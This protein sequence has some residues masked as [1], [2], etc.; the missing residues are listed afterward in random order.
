MGSSDIENLLPR[1]SQRFRGINKVDIIFFFFFLCVFCLIFVNLF[2][3]RN[4][5]V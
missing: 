2:F 4:L 5:L 1:E 3:S